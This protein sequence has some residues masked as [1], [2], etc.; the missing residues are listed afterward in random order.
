MTKVIAIANQ[1]GGVGKTTTTV[2]L[3]AGLVQKGY[4]VLLIDADAQGNLTDSLGWHTPDELPTTLANHMLNLIEHEQI[5][6]S[7]GILHHV[8]GMDLLPANIGL[9]ALEVSL[10]NALSRETILKRYIERIKDRYDFILIDCMPSLGMITINA[11]VAAD[12]VLIPVQAHYL[13]A[14][15]MTQLLQTIRRV[16][17]I[18]PNLCISGA[19]MTMTDKCTNFTKDISTQ[20]RELYGAHLNVFTTEIPRAIRIAESSANGVSIFAHDPKGKAAE[21]YAAFTHELLEGTQ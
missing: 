18:N 5:D 21:A 6:P 12:A 11:L 4:R 7:E 1:K 9:S 19:L 13:P 10:V 20:L 16:Q 8:E 15:G 3:G 2:N 17:H 14:K